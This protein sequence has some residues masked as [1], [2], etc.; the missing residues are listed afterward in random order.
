MAIHSSLGQYALNPYTFET[1][2]LRV[3]CIEELCYVIKENAFLLDE[4][5]LTKEMIE[6]IVQDLHLPEL[7]MGLR[8]RLQKHC[9]LQE[10]VVF[11]LEYTGFYEAD[12]IRRIQEILRKGE[13]RN[14]YERM[15]LRADSYARRK[16]YASALSI[17]M[18]IHRKLQNEEGYQQDRISSF[19]TSILHNEGV[20]FAMLM[21]YT[22]AAAC[23]QKAYKASADEKELFAYL[24]AVR[25][26]KSDA[27]YIAF[28][29]EHPEYFTQSLLV[30]QRLEEMKS[31]WQR[32][33][34][35][36]SLLP[37]DP[38]DKTT[39]NPLIHEMKEKYRRMFGA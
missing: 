9:P 25:L 13:G 18:E 8:E 3:Y 14:Q 35:P 20:I 30:E 34:D 29:A 27:E 22:E 19:E 15:K 38:N 11:L 28:A 24:A 31:A 23:F 4:E 10:Q 5:F 37:N 39:W 26:Q 16:R 12:T 21:R 7:A 1:L 36:I 33:D 2:G 6:W 17:Y 32:E